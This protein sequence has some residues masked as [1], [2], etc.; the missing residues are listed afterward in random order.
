MFELLH[1]Y[2]K[3]QLTERLK[4]G[5][6]WH[7][8]GKVFTQENGLAMHPDSITGWVTKFR[9]AN[10]LPHFSPHSLRHTSATLLIM[11]GAP[12][13]A[14]SAR[15]GHA[16]QNTTNAIYSHAIK[17]ADAMASDILG[18]VLRPVDSRLS[19]KSG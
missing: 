9:E 5:D 18:D 17:T 10:N 7:D 6:R 19:K 4:M 11:Q 1:E 13:K 8:T 2:R 3:W 16:N 12:V 14:V 15:L